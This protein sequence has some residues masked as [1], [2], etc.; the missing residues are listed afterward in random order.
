MPKIFE[1]CGIIFLFYSDD[2]LPVHV[3][4][5]YQQY[6]NKIEF[7]YENGEFVKLK[8]KKVKGYEVLPLSKLKDATLFCKSYH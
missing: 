5:Q 6:Q 4:A 2:H 3:H 1:Y 7:V 8:I